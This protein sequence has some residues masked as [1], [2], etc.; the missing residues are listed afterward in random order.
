MN[1][2]NPDKP[3][4]IPW[5]SISLILLVFV[6]LMCGMLARTPIRIK[7]NV[8]LFRSYNIE[9]RLKGVTNLL[10][11]GKRGEAALAQE[12]HQGSE[13]AAFLRK[14]WE[15]IGNKNEDGLTWLHMSV[16]KG[17][18]DAAELLIAHGLEINGTDYDNRTPLHLAVEKRDMELIEFFVRSGASADKKN[19]FYR[20]CLHVAA[21]NGFRD[22]VILLLS[23]GAKIDPLDIHGCTPLHLAVENHHSRTVRLLVAKGANYNTWDGRNRTALSISISNKY[24]DLE[25][26]FTE[27]RAITG[28]PRRMETRKG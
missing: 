26:Y 23:S 19:V 10:G 5:R 9:N 14:S 4:L 13:E 20:T 11:M 24:S 2:S 1:G 6:P 15:N 27:L 21:E 22:A 3:Q 16:L 12:L 17:Y 8:A 7:R 28:P 25:S 18:R